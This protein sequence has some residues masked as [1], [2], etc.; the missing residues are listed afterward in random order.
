MN[1]L[2]QI[3]GVVYRT[4]SDSQSPPPRIDYAVSEVREYQQPWVYLVWRCEV[5]DRESE[6]GERY[7]IVETFVDRDSAIEYAVRAAK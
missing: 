7:F 4:A 2:Y 3:K 1:Y 6:D 5:P